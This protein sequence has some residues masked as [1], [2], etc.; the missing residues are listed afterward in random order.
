VIPNLEIGAARSGRS[1]EG[2]D[3][4]VGL[5]A[6]VGTEQSVDE[7][8]GQVVMFAT[9]LGSSPAYATSIELAGFG[10]QGDEIRQ[11]VESGDI[12][13]ALVTVTP[14]MVD[15]LTISGT[16]EN[17]RRRVAEYAAAG[18]TSVVLNPS[19]PGGYYP[20]YGGHLDGI[21]VPEFDFGGYLGVIEATIG[22][23]AD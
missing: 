10:E 14:A 12:E 8:R 16:A 22:A 13:G 23:M 18:A 11:R 19:A 9:A 15:A 6:N 4:G 21:E 2:F 5:P 7:L 1:L 20:L 17:A 3:V